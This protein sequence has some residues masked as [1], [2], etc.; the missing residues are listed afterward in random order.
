MRPRF[1]LTKKKAIKVIKKF[2]KLFGVVT[3]LFLFLA[4][5]AYWL[6]SDFW[7]I[8]K[9]TCRLNGQ[10]CPAPT[11]A[12]LM[13]LYQ[14]KRIF[15]LSTQTIAR[16]IKSNF[17]AL[18]QVEVKKQLPDGLFFQLEV[19]KP[20]AAVVDENKPE[21]F[22]YLVDQGGVFLEKATAS[23]GLPLVVVGDLSEPEIGE[24]FAPRE[25]KKAVSLLIDLQLRL[26]EPKKAKIISEKEIDFWLKNDTQASFSLKK[27]LKDQLDSLQLI[28]TRT[29]IEGKQPKRIDLRFDK[30]VVVYE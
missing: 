17:S 27:D 4:L 9:I 12:A 8:K 10:D 20:R 1:F 7:R 25:V 19:R 23:G 15:F 5:L 30:P 13:G 18:D 29:K 16:E 11:R 22:F 6:R 26:L 14:A 24:E 3:F 2:F 21:E 28:Y